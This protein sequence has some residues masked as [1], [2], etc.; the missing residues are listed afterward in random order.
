MGVVGISSGENYDIFGRAKKGWHMFLFQKFSRFMPSAGRAVAVA[1]ICVAAVTVTGVLRVWA[2]DDDDTGYTDNMRKQQETACIMAGGC[3]NRPA[4]NNRGPADTYAAVAISPS[5]QDTGI[6]WSAS[7][8][9]QAETLAIQS[10]AKEG[11]N[12]DCKSVLWAEDACVAIAISSKTLL[13]AAT[14]GF[15]RNVNRPAANAQA[16]S[17][18]NGTKNMSCAVQQAACPSDP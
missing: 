5:T 4:Q 14:W 10:C 8:Q 3:D 1:V 16:I 7:S 12:K 17:L 6:S 18:C 11:N 9:S 2:Q 13:P 15:S